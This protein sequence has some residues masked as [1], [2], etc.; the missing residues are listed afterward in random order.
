MPKMTE[1]STF[2]LGARRPVA[3]GSANGNVPIMSPENQP[4]LL[5]FCQST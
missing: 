5:S 3:V 2:H 1:I 4:L